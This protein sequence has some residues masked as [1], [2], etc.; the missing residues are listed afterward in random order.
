MKRVSM[1]STSAPRGERQS[2]A[3][4]APRIVPSQSPFSTDI[5]ALYAKRL[6]H[7]GADVTPALRNRRASFP[8]TPE[9]MVGYL[10]TSCASVRCPAPVGRGTMTHRQ[11]LQAMEASQWAL[12]PGRLPAPERVRVTRAAAA[13]GA[14]RREGVGLVARLVAALSADR[15]PS[16]PQRVPS[17]DRLTLKPQ[18]G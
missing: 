1:P 12:V 2:S 17:P 5:I 7:T 15:R 13:V 10:A 18:A 8:T 3:R 14:S 6:Q 4:T 16:R 11:A 9:P